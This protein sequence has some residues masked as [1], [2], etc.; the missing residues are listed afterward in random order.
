VF[1][2]NYILIYLLFFSGAIA[3]SQPDYKVEGK[4]FTSLKKA[5][6]QPDSVF[7]LKL[8]RKGY[9]EIPVEIF[10]FKNLKELDLVGNKIIQIDPKIGLLTKLE[11]LKLSR[12]QIQLI[13][14][15][16]AKLNALKYLDV[17]L[18]KINA[19]PEEMKTMQSLEFLQIWG[20]ELTVIP[21]T[22]SKMP[23]L[24]WLDMRAIILT[25]TEKED[26]QNDFPQVKVLFS[27]GCNCGK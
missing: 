26:I 4:L 2:I 7:R 3:F 20:N 6:V 1:K 16:I 15:S 14:T 9:R 27:P 23:N 24:K 19:L 5:M 11:I 22:I 25:E 13:P 17:G 18:N 8:K 10:N 12:N 21:E